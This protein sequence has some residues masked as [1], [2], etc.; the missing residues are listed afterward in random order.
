MELFLLG[1]LVGV[2]G[3]KGKGALK[4]L[5]RGYLEL[6]DRARAWG[7]ELREEFED[8][9]AE[10][11]YERE[12]EAAGS[13]EDSLEATAGKDAPASAAERNGPEPVDAEP[14]AR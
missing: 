2:V 11:R 3:A 9:L 8:V 12:Q 14:V 13:Q 7:A 1:I 5:A 6:S 10:A 4:P